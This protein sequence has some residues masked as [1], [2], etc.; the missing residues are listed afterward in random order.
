MDS[1]N[2]GVVSAIHPH[3]A[4]LESPVSDRTKLREIAAAEWTVEDSF[5]LE[6]DH[7]N[8]DEKRDEAEN[9]YAYDRASIHRI[10]AMCGCNLTHAHPSS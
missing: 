7:G 8:K 10:S 9:D 6:I 3:S 4:Y 2:H 5:R 1:E